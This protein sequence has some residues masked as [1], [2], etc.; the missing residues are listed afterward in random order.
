SHIVLVS[1]DICYDY[2]EADFLSYEKSTVQM[3][4]GHIEPA[5]VT[6]GVKNSSLNEMATNTDLI[7]VSIDGEGKDKLLDEYDFCIDDEITGDTYEQSEDVET[8][9]VMNH[10]MASSELS[11]DAV[12][13]ITETFFDNLDAIHNSHAAAEDITLEDA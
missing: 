8:V 9:G 12:Y 6:S 1:Y 13:D 3:S 11:E 4:N 5:F 7:V 10:L 2:M